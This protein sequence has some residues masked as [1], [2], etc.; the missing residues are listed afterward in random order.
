MR[1]YGFRRTRAGDLSEGF[2][3]EQPNVEQQSVNIDLQ[4]I[5]GRGTLNTKQEGG[6]NEDFEFGL[7][8]RKRRQELGLSLRELACRTDLTASF[9]SQLERGLTNASID[10]LRRIAA[11]LGVSMLHFLAETPKRSPVVRKDARA[12]LPLSDSGLVYELLVPDLARKMEVFIGKIK[13]GKGN[14]ARAPLR[15]PTEE[16]IHML[17]GSLEVGLDDKTYVLHAGD[18]IYFEGVQLASLSNGSDTEPARWISIITPPV[19]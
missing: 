6:A 3:G 7:K 19:F 10:S 2:S 1:Y 15:K 17:E 8:I 11:G 12:R 4:S 13:P 14:F 9:L 5:K 16:C 18:S